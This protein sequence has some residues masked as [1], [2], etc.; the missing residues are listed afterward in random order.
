MSYS[1]L[2]PLFGRIVQTSECTY[3]GTDAIKVQEEFL[4]DRWIIFYRRWS[5]DLD[6]IAR[7]YLL[8]NWVDNNYESRNA[9]VV[10]VGISVDKDKNHIVIKQDHTQHCIYVFENGN[11]A[12]VQVEELV[13]CSVFLRHEKVEGAEA[14]K[15]RV[16]ASALRRHSPERGDILDSKMVATVYLRKAFVV[17]KTESDYWLDVYTWTDARWFLCQ[18]YY[19]VDS[20]DTRIPSLRAPIVS[21]FVQDALIQGAVF[22][23]EESEPLRWWHVYEGDGVVWRHRNSS[24]AL[25]CDN[26]IYP[27]GKLVVVMFLGG[28]RIIM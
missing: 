17:E 5:G 26:I 2:C 28:G 9:P 19:R 14:I 6:V 7:Y 3:G 22:V 1:H 27:L 20:L 13:M 18:S 25:L 11:S 16:A 8:N 10:D 21:I 15:G 12:G 24:S 4:A 23:V